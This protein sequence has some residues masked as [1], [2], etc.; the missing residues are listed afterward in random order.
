[1]LTAL[2]I[3]CWRNCA[4]A[5]VIYCL[6]IVFLFDIK[7]VFILCLKETVVFLKKMTVFFLNI[8]VFFLNAVVFHPKRGHVLSETR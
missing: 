8:T 5:W 3:G 4:N 1:M 7:Q 2:M 6:I